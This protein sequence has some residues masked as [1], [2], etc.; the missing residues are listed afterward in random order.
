M[1]WGLNPGPM[2]FVERP[3]FVWGLIASMYLGNVV[4]VVLVLATIPL[5]ASI[6]RIPFAIIGPIIV[7]V[8][9]IGAF[10]VAG[11]PFDLWLALAFGVAGYVFKKLDYPIAPLVLAMVL[12]DKA[13]D[14]FRQSMIMSKGSVSIFW[15]NGLVTTL[16]AL[17][18]VLLFWPVL[19]Q[20]VRRVAPSRASSATA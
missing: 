10:T 6:L 13:E 2:L 14:A 12:G 1:I 4:A 5:F 11:R 8:C 3:D 16:M 7:V 20:L 18:L 17:G 9:F 19:S 15:S